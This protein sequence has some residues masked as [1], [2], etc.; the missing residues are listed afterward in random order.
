M[1]QLK[2][3]PQFPMVYGMLFCGLLIG[4]GPDFSESR[5]VIHPY[6]LCLLPPFQNGL[7]KTSDLVSTTSNRLEVC[8]MLLE[9]GADCRVLP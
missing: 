8:E 7:P 5:F 1:K 2:S 3:F 9:G 4:N 6:E